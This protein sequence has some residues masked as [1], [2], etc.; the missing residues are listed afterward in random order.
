MY[1]LTVVVISRET[2]ER[3]QWDGSRPKE[4]TRDLGSSAGTISSQQASLEG[5]SKISWAFFSDSRHF[6][7]SLGSANCEEDQASKSSPT[8]L[9]PCSKR[10][11]SL[12][13]VIVMIFI[14]YLRN[15]DLW[16]ILSY[17]VN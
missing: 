3:A 9:A 11:S 7:R 4:M 6:S 10:G 16:N 13:Q 2:V 14:D 15:N 17:R 12:L 1:R 5:W 8:S